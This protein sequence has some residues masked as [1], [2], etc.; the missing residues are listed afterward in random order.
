MFLSKGL[1]TYNLSIREHPGLKARESHKIKHA[2]RREEGGG[3]G[4]GRSSRRRKGGRAA[5]GAARPVVAS[6]LHCLTLLGGGIHRGPSETLA[7]PAQGV[8][9]ERVSYDAGE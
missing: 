6:P 4:G 3:A 7:V 9:G 1:F 8:L 2:N 5:K